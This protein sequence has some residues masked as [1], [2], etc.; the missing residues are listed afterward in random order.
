MIEDRTALNAR[1]VALLV[2]NGTERLCRG[3]IVDEAIPET[4]SARYDDIVSHFR[5]VYSQHGI[6]ITDA[7]ARELV[8]DQL[9]KGKDENRYQ[10][11]SGMW[12]RK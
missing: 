4:G 10:E 3:D 7:L 9:H 8:S 11:S 5:L 1:E 2:G 12:Y 6:A